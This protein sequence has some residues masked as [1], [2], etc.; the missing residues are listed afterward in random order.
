MFFVASLFFETVHSWGQVERFERFA[1]L[2]KPLRGERKKVQSTPRMGCM[3][4]IC[5]QRKAQRN[6]D[7]KRTD[8]KITPP[9]ATKTKHW[10]VLIIALPRGTCST[11]FPGERKISG[12][13]V[14]VSQ[15]SLGRFPTIMKAQVWRLPSSSKSPRGS[16][17]FQQQQQQNEKH[18][19]EKKEKQCFSF[20]LS[21]CVSLFAILFFC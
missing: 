4:R 13:L 1:H 2:R 17:P 14:G 21:C 20:F 18:R 9:P 19:N 12:V 3:A 10:H 11:R 6:R 5:R 8:R 16:C 7:Q 15:W